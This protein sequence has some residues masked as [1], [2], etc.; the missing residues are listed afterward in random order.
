[1]EKP[2][3]VEQVDLTPTLALGLGLPISQNSVG[4][5]IPGVLEETSLRDQLR[6]LH[7]NGHQLS[8]LLKDSIPDYK[9]GEWE[10]H[11]V[12]SPDWETRPRLTGSL[13]IIW[14]CLY[15]CYRL[16]GYFCLSHSNYGY[17][18]QLKVSLTPKR[19]W[20]LK[21]VLTFHFILWKISSV[22]WYSC[23]TYT[24]LCSILCTWALRVRLVLMQMKTLLVMKQQRVI[25]A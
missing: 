7:L 3:V 9:K 4:Q 1:M 17:G 25:V 21:L 18:K 14:K 16:G 23:S 12:L 13:I 24:F 22:T 11:C 10:I 5:V 2:R 8:C 19:K 15:F 20:T 6:F